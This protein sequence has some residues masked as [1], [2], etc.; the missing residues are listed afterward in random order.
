MSF[1]QWYLHFESHSGYA[2]LSTSY[3]GFLLRTA[4]FFLDGLIPGPC[5]CCCTEYVNPEISV[6]YQIVGF[7]CS[8]SE[9][10][11][12]LGG[13]TAYGG[14]VP[15]SRI[16]LFIRGP[17]CSSETS[18]SNQPTLRNI[19]EYGRILLCYVWH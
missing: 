7:R 13:Y 3:W 14:S 8:L 16:K 9:F 18:A 11:R 17:I 15:S 1:E 4:R 10:F 12:L 5:C 6:F 19:P 2:C